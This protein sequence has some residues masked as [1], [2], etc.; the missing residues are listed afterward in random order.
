MPRQC[1]SG[2]N[3]SKTI[4]SISSWTRYATN[5]FGG[6][7]ENSIKIFVRACFSYFFSTNG[8]PFEKSRYALREV[9]GKRYI[10]DSLPGA[11]LVATSADG[12]WESK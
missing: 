11:M 1:S 2:T 7:R 6:E 8:P 9:E 10:G 4:K 3:G 5:N 12:R